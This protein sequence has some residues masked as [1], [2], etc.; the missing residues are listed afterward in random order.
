MDNSGQLQV[1]PYI[2]AFKLGEGA[3]ARVFHAYEAADRAKSVAL[4]VFKFDVPHEFN[5]ALVERES[6][7]LKLSSHDGVVKLLD[8]STNSTIT[9][10]PS[11]NSR[12]VC[13]M[14]TELCA[15]GDLFDLITGGPLNEKIC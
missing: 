15:N 1:G 9:K 12:P 5:Q 10:K 13:Y 2:L 3:Y 14:A 8:Y 4:K 7:M 11:G 6:S